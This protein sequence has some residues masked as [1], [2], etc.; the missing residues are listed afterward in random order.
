MYYVN[1]IIKSF[2]RTNQPE[3]RGKYVRLD[4]N[5]NPDGIPQWLFDRAMPLS[6]FE[7]KYMYDDK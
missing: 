3:G 2:F 7:K 5:E 1:P 6:D 4:Q